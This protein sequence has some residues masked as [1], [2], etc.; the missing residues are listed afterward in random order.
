M[1]VRAAKRNA[2]DTA[3]EFVSFVRFPVRGF[4]P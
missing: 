1:A 4:A 3:D 2:A